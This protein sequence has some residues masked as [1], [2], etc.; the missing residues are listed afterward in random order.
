MNRHYY[1]DPIAAF[2]D[3]DDDAIL[4]LLARNSDFPIEPMQRDAWLEEIRILKSVLAPHRTQGKLYFEYAIPRLGRRIDVVALIDHVI[5][6][7]E[8]KVGERTFPAHAIDQV[9][10]YGLDLKN[11]HETSHHPPI[12]PVLI[13]TAAS[14][15]NPNVR[16]TAER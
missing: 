2:L 15:A 11:F 13:A 9:W 5:F 6:V 14:H 1:S 3:K 8:F 4:G 7:L 16:R 10:D 12:T